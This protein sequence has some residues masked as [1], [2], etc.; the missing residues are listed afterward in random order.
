[1]PP[2]RELSLNLGKKGIKTVSP[3]LKVRKQY[4]DLLKVL[5]KHILSLVWDNDDLKHEK[6]ATEC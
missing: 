3:L 1:M 2:K 5:M 6:N 4:V